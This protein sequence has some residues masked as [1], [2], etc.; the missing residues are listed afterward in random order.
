MLLFSKPVDA[1]LNFNMILINETEKPKKISIF[2]RPS[3]LASLSP[4]HL[5]KRWGLKINNDDFERSFEGEIPNKDEPTFFPTEVYTL[6]TKSK[7]Y[8]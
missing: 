1:E 2:R 7:V 3:E 5:T 4:L 8:N 6:F